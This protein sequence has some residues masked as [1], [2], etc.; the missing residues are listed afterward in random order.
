MIWDIIETRLAIMYDN[1]LAGDSL[2]SVAHN[3]H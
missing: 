1:Y 3:C 2:E